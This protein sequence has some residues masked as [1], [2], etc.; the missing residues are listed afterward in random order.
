[1]L[2]LIHKLYLENHFNATDYYFAQMIANSQEE[3]YPTSKSDLAILLASLCSYQ[4]RSGHTC[5]LLQDNLAQNPF[6]LGGNLYGYVGKEIKKKIIYPVEQ[7][8][9]VLADHP[10]F[11]HNPQSEIKPLV[12]F[13]NRVYFYGTWRNELK[14]A[15]FFGKFLHNSEGNSHNPSEFSEKFPSPSIRKIKD[16]LDKFFPADFTQKL[17]S[18]DFHWQ[19]IAVA[20]AIKQPFTIIT[21]GPG[22]GKTTTVSRLLLAL[23][24][25]YA[26]QLTIKLVAPTGKAA[27]RLSESLWNAVERLIQVEQVPI[28]EELRA[29][30]PPNAETIH[31][32]LGISYVD[33][34]AKF[35][36]KNPIEADILVVDEASMI[37]LSSMAKLVEA[38]PSST[39]LIL[40]GDQDQLASVEAGSVLAELTQF[41]SNTQGNLLPY[42]KAQVEY[43]QATT[44]ELLPQGAGQGMRDHLCQLIA[45]RR[46]GEHPQIGELAN[47]INQQRAE[48][49]WQTL[50]EFTHSATKDVRIVDYSDNLADKNYLNEVAQK[51]VAKAVQEYEKYLINLK[52]LLA[53]KSS[54]DQETPI[55]AYLKDIFAMFNEVRFLTAVRNGVFGSEWLNQQIFK[56]L[57]KLNIL[58]FAQE[59]YLGK[60][61]L[62]MKNDYHLNLYN[63]D[64]GIYLITRNEYGEMQGRY[65]FENGKSELAS[66]LPYHESA[67]A[68][69]VHKSQGSEFDHAYLVLPNQ[70]SP[71]LT[72]EL[73]YTGVTRAKS[74]IIIFTNQES[75]CW[76][77]N[78]ATQR[79]SGLGDQINYEQDRKV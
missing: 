45:S 55:Q 38:I 34:P 69:T 70:L 39:K 31:R 25:L 51:I 65:W 1:M 59:N 13:N 24:E 53:E 66:R 57:K 50:Q 62:I 5:V 2:N 15:Q 43:L 21:G 8:A 35:N 68:M 10:A 9:E 36:S 74:K 14:I 64:I 47:L 49:S 78:R 67:F 27:A 77:V 26:N 3:N 29:S 18:E 11:T 4:Q 6:K 76:A 46:F 23:Q 19:K 56:Q 60:P 20:I 12:F 72:K 7:W 54:K 16:A 28:S 75:W 52:K 61:I 71:V 42:S 33:K 73:L 32:L 79:Q 17:P 30:L 44:G 37:D 48:E 40:L 63:G 58:E 41:Q 22:T